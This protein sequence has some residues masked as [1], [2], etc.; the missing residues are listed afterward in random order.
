MTRTPL[1]LRVRQA[2]E[3]YGDRTVVESASGGWKVSGEQLLA[4]ASQL[5]EALRP[6]AGRPVVAYLPKSPTFYTLLACSFVNRLRFCPLDTAN[7]IAR[8]IDVARQLPDALILVDSDD[9]LTRVRDYTD[10]CVLVTVRSETVGC[11]PAEPLDVS[12]TRDACYYI[13]TS[14]STGTPKLVEVP[15]E[16]TIPFIDWAVAF[17]GIDRYTR[18]AQFSSVGFDLALADFLS[19]V[20]GGGTLVSLSSQMDRIRPAKTVARCRITHWHSVPSIIPYFLRDSG[21]DATVSTCRVF[22]FCGETLMRTDAESLA[23]RYQHARIINTYGPTE[24]TL[25]CSFYEYCPGESAPAQPSLPIGHP[26]PTWNFVLVPDD[27]AFRLIILSDNVARGYAGVPSAQFST[28]DLFG[29]PI[30]AFD[31]GDYFRLAGAH[32]Y[33]SHRRDG[34]VKVHGNRVDLGEIEAAAKKSGLVNPVAVVVANTIALAAEGEWRPEGEVVDELS[35]YLPRWALPSTV[36]FVP[37]HRRTVNGKLD[38]RA[39]LEAIETQHEH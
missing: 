25:F 7:P 28:V 34:L 1:H 13:A 38:R 2:L 27:G 24:T 4:G 26:I 10:D 37:T 18:W 8:L 36:V 20:C 14:G 23:S 33:F 17:Y 21:D 32:L 9:V 22:S 11:R 29:R 3:C 15:H 30:S 16:R 31:T 19:V 39:V 35:R 5:L 12:G 6:H